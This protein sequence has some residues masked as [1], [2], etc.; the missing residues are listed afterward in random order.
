MLAVWSK[1]SRFLTRPV[2][3]LRDYEWANLKPDALAGLTMAVIVLPQAIAY[4]SVAELPPQT[5]LYAA[6]VAAIVGGLWGASNHLHTGPTNAAS[7]LALTILLPIAEPGSPEFLAA[8]GVMA[9]MV[10]VFRLFLGLARLGMLANFVSDSVIIGFTAGAGVLISVNQIRPLLRL[11]FPSSPALLA[12]LQQVKSHVAET[13]MTSLYLGLGV[14]L[15]MI[16]TRYFKPKWPVLLLSMSAAALLVAAFN[17]TGMGVQ[18][19]GELPNTLPPIANLSFNLTLISQLSAGALAVSAIGLIE[20]TA[21]ARSIASQSGQRLDSNQE[22]VGQGLANIA[23]GFFSG[24]TVSGSFTRTTINYEAGARTALS[25]VFSGIFVLL[26]MIIFGPFAAYVPR[27]ALASV[28]LVS[29]YS[30]VDRKEIRRIVR[31]TR[32]DSIIMAITFFATL[33]LPLQFAVLTGI[34]ISFAVYILRTSLPRIV[35]VLPE[36]NYRHFTHQPDSDP[37]SQLAIIDILGDLYFGAINHVED[38]LNQ[39]LDERPQQRFLLL[40]MHN[41]QQCDISGIH[42]LEAIIE[43]MY[44]R[45]GDVFFM[46][47]RQPVMKMMRAT[48]MYEKLGDDHFLK[49]ENAIPHLFTRILDPAICVYECRQRV[50]LECQNLPRPEYLPEG[51]LPHTAIPTIKVAMISPQELWEQLRGQSPPLVIDVREPREFQSGHIPQA[52]SMPLGRIIANPTLIP[53]N[54]RVVF[55]CRGGR[56]SLRMAAHLMSQGCD[57]VYALTGGI[58]AWERS[59]LL[60]AVDV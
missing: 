31:G 14:L 29:A 37:C 59:D 32:G 21:I 9:V 47:V 43:K 54:T 36:K 16:L 1:T 41:V 12:T 39:Q 35:P 38:S 57:Q 50:F 53:Q 15:L 18:V 34:M 46:R 8:A 13:H 25:S 58:L 56:R 17:L 60:E 10:G 22:F 19:I 20:A 27:A 6:V 5:G 28:L 48:G 26:A 40:R 3:L 49:Y 45:G 44:D 7:L 33:L 23:C 42:M 4:A 2:Q 55:V 52:E 51:A 24:Y 30:L 11:D